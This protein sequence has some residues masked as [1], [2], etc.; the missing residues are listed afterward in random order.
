MNLSLETALALFRRMPEYCNVDLD[1]LGIQKSDLEL[2]SGNLPWRIDQSDT[3]MRVLL[4]FV[5]GTVRILRLPPITVP[6]EY[7]APIIASAVGPGNQQLACIWMAQEKMTGAGAMDL[8]ARAATGQMNPTSADQ[9]FALVC[10]LTAQGNY[11]Y[12]RERFATAMGYEILKASDV[13]AGA[14]PKKGK[15]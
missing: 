2:V 13:E 11:S 15:P 8:S 6:S 7:I 5:H 9:L 1:A 12:Y 10:L 3:V 4:A 14:T